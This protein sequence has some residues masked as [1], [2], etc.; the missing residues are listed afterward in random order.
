MGKA[1]G[2]RTA[3]GRARSSQNAAKHWITSGRIL[4]T[5][6]RDAAILRG[7][8]VEDFKPQGTIENEMID[9]LV[10]NRLIKRRI[11]SAFTRE[12]SK[13][14][15][16]KLLS[17]MEKS[18]RSLTHYFHRYGDEVGA[19]GREWKKG[20]RLCPEE[21]VQSLE[22]LGFEIAGRGPKPEDLLELRRIYGNEPSGYGALL[23]NLF[24]PITGKLSADDNAET[25]DAMRKEE[26]LREL[27]YEIERQKQREDIVADLEKV[28]LSSPVQEPSGPALGTLLRYRA[29]NT[30]EFST[31]L[32]SLRSIRRLRGGKA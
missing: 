12:F 15:M 22:A 31:L 6:Q 3:K 5:E 17:A 9:D 8:F 4:K 18:E 11:D 16:E 20:E 23:M 2:P 28:D 29:A 1:T 13:A 27:Q 26:I 14:N 30:R 24:L 32:A 19:L 7:G 10:F 25:N 21:C